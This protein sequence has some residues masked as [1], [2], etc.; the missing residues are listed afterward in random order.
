[1]KWLTYKYAQ[2][3]HNTCRWYI[4][5]INTI[6]YT[7]YNKIFLAVEEHMIVSGDCH[8]ISIRSSIVLSVRWVLLFNILFWLRTLRSPLFYCLLTP[9]TA[10]NKSR[11][12]RQVKRKIGNR[13]HFLYV[14]HEKILMTKQ[15]KLRRH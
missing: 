7:I 13:I 15:Y 5:G 6:K 11:I 10:I 1:M 8:R 3:I 4:L 14:S 9:S 2:C 12:T